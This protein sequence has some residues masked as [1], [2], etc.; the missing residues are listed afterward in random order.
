[1]PQGG[2]LILS[3]EGKLSVEASK[4][5]EREDI[6]VLQSLPIE[7]CLP[8]SV[9]NYV[10]RTKESL[11]LNDASREGNFSKD[12]YLKQHQTKSILCA[13]L[14]NQ[15]QL[16]SIVYLENNLSEGAFTQ[17]RL[18]VVKLLSSQAA[19]SI[20]N[21]RLYTSLE[22][23]VAQR[24]QELSETLDN[25][26]ATQE[27]L[28]QSEKMAALGQLVAGVAH[29]INTPLGAI[30]SS[31]NNIASFLKE[32]L[33]ESYLFFQELSPERQRD[34][35]ALVETSL[36]RETSFSTREKRQF[37]KNL[38]SELE[39]EEIEKADTI[40]QLLVSM[41][42]YEDISPF[43]PLLK[44]KEGL[45]ILKQ[46]NQLSNVQTSTRTIT[47]ATD[48][49]G[50]VVFALKSYA[51]YDTSGEKV[52]ANIINGIETVLTLYQNQLKQGVEVVRNYVDLAPISCY[53]DELNQVWTNLV[54]NALQAMENK[55]TLTID[56]GQEGVYLQ[57]KMTDT[58]TGIPEEI[59]SKIFDP[60]FTTKPPGEGSGLGLDIV[61]KIVAKH[62]G[63]IEVASQ[64]GQTTFAVLLPINSE[65]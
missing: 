28:V 2:H 50:K 63:K 65:N 38:K 22:I 1:M 29:E 21:A 53:P 35:F 59:M 41:G 32:T 55:G 52:N 24:T 57:V 26:R 58:G 20:E 5:I 43:L 37:R 16:V 44:D 8:V 11:V 19:I 25:L 6:S 45:N 15:G 34:F 54:H 40:A 42:I 10:A 49:A 47:T 30:G 51:R 3:S 62:D 33:Q 17:E 60:F 14:I 56:V 7:S 46:A 12:A 9:I 23:K 27:E 18:E 13:P 39:A 48:R 61:K 4:E 31:I 36:Q 64:P